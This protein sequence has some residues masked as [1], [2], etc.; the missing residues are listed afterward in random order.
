MNTILTIYPGA[1]GDDAQDWA[2]MLLRMYQRFC[3]KKKLVYKKNKKFVL[4]IKN[5]Y[6]FLQQEAGVHRLVRQSPFSA[7]KLRHTSFAL[8]EVLPELKNIQIEINPQDLRIDTFRASGPGGQYVNKTESAV[9]MTHLPTG[10]VSACQTERSQAQNKEKALLL[11]KAK[12]Y[13]KEQNKAKAEQAEFKTGLSPE[14]GNQIRSYVLHPYKMVRNEITGKKH[15]NVDE[16][17]DGNL[18]KL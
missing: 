8:V 6:D 17:L 2:K 7:K 14:W 4:E 10:F 13:A 18:D 15:Y 16:I 12:L 11:L 5:G 3:D 9:R 1:G